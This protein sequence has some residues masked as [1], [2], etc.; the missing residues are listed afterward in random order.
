MY[1]AGSADHCKARQLA[2]E[3]IRKE[4]DDESYVSF[5]GGKDSIVL[6]YLCQLVKRDVDVFHWDHGA[7]LMPR[8][9]EKGIQ[10]S[11]KIIAPHA[12]LHIHEFR[13]GKETRSRYDYQ[14]WYRAF[15]GS[16]QSFTKQFGMKKAFLGIRS[17]ESAKRAVRTSRSEDS[18]KVYPIAHLTWRDVWA[19]IVSEKLPYP[20]VYDLYAE[21]L[22]Y[23]R[24]RLVTFHD[25]E[26]DKFGSRNLD[27]VLMWKEKHL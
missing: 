2:T 18:G 12:K 7:A 19:V 5:S 11:I 17:E 24:V 1:Y 23:D 27:N 13:F 20:A 16:L 10:S 15:Y 8:S 21:L 26:F 9:V 6:L 4:L 22:G 3:K 25:S 14:K